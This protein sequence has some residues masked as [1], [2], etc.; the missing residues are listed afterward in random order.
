MSSIAIKEALHNYIDSGD[1]K[2]LQMIYAMVREYNNPVLSE[3]DFI[4]LENRTKRRESG[5]SKIHDWTTAKEMMT[6]K[7]DIKK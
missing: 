5:E 1:D 3:E 4:N 6:G 7:R 2:L